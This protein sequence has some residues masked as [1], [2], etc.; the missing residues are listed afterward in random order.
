M[1]SKHAIDALTDEERRLME[2]IEADLDREMAVEPSPDFAARVRERISAADR[3][4]GWG[5]PW[6]FAAAAVVT[7]VTGILLAGL[8]GQP[9]DAPAIVAGHDVAL[10]APTSPGPIAAARRPA[11]TSWRVSGLPSNVSAGSRIDPRLARA[12][13][14]EVLV[15]P[16]FRLAIDRV[17]R[18]VR[19]GT[20]NPTR[21][22]DAAGA[23]NQLAS[24]PER[25][26]AA[27]EEPAEPVA[28]M[29]VEELQVPPINLAGGG[30]EKGFGLN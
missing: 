4:S 22:V 5:V 1:S 10:P 21:D 13:E 15:P 30:L 29:I 16:E 14:P 26:T 24:R 19:A 27:A 6:A 25:A 2:T 3:D 28:P 8:R 11:V 20:L 9:V 17:M 18:M 7:I 12:S 23:G